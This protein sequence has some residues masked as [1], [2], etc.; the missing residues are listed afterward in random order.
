MLK[1]KKSI[2]MQLQ[3]T[4]DQIMQVEEMLSAKREA[5]RAD[6]DDEAAEKNASA[7]DQEQRRRFEMEEAKREEEEEDA[8]RES[9][10]TV[11]LD[12]SYDGVAEDR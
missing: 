11:A 12:D 7:E 3:Q 9:T 6:S 5:R 10:A 2:E 4:E 1:M 8:D